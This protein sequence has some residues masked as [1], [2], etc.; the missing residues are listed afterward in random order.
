MNTKPVRDD[1]EDESCSNALS[2]Y[3]IGLPLSARF[4]HF[5][6]STA[7]G[8]GVI[9]AAQFISAQGYGSRIGAVLFLAFAVSI[10]LRG[11]KLKH[12]AASVGSLSAK[13]AIALL[14]FQFSASQLIEVGWAGFAALIFVMVAAFYGGLLGARLVKAP[15]P[16]GIL[17][18]GAAAICGV[19]AAAVIFAILGPKRLPQREYIGAI[20]AIIT[21]STATVFTSTIIASRFDLNEAQIAF[22]FGSTVHDAAQAI[23]GAYS[24]GDAVGAQA[25]IIKTARIAILVPFVIL[26]AGAI[27]P[28]TDGVSHRAGSL[29]PPVYLGF[30]ALLATTNTLGL[31]PD[32]IATVGGSAAQLMLLFAIAMT[33]LGVN[34]TRLSLRSWTGVFGACA[35]ATILGL[36]AATGSLQFI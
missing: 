27:G 15:S 2:E 3:R 12:S 34:V 17:M 7:V 23:A 31:V 14:G 35:G 13:L 1:G 36:I 20:F 9:G 16:A 33:I 18:G 24:F 30:F 32:C 22:L 11:H 28:R 8:A 10:A 25:T 21:A 4:T 26:L 5:T 19:S 29:M 6:S